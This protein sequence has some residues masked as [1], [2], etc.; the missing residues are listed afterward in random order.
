[1]TALVGCDDD[2]PSD[3]TQGGEVVARDYQFSGG[4]SM[5]RCGYNAAEINGES[6]TELH[7]DGLP[8]ADGVRVVGF[9]SPL[10]LLGYK[11]HVIDDKFVAKGGL[12]LGDLEGPA[13]LGST[14]L[15][16]LSSGLTVPVIIAES[17]AV[18]SW[19]AGAAPITA[20][21]LVYVDLGNP[22][23]Y[24]N[25]CTGTLL[26]PLT[27]AVT[28]IGGETYDDETKTV[29]PNMTNWFTLACAGSAAAKMKLMNYGPNSDFDGAGN[30]ATVMQRQATLKMITADYCGGGVSY[31]ATGTPIHW[32]NASGLVAPDPEEP[33]GAFEA[34]WDGDGALCLDAPR[35]PD[36]AASL[37]CNL[38]P[39][40]PG[41]IAAGE[42]RTENVVAE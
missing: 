9:L 35:R 36:L 40:T 31:T 10:A 42:W 19:A 25:V 34:S 30:P 33:L 17:G 11:L 6:L 3:F 14:I 28:L 4:C 5:W 8:N 29:N 32:T 24:S 26:D 41:L 18:D 16:K 20:Y 27:S 13:L 21:T 7:R 12:L 15:I 23:G 22:L 38:P 2:A 37:E 1:M 39:C